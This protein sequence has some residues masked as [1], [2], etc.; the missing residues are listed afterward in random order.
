MLVVDCLSGVASLLLLSISVAVSEE[1]DRRTGEIGWLLLVQGLRN[2]SIGD[3]TGRER[4]SSR[5]ASHGEQHGA[6]AI[7]ATDELEDDDDA[8]RLSDVRQSMQPDR[9]TA[10]AAVI[11]LSDTS[12]FEQPELIESHPRRP[13]STA[14]PM[15]SECS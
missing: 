4:S 11:R 2:G 9:V 14:I 1:P 7:T 12:E 3:A 15:L 5:A 6:N 8:T 13:A 10:A